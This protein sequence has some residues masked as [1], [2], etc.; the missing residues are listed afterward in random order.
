MTMPSI[1]VIGAGLSGTITALNLVRATSADTRVIVFERGA[2]FGPGLAYATPHPGHLL[3]VPAGRMSAFADR[4]TDFLDWLR[5][6][7][8]EERGG[9]DP[10]PGT[11]A[12]RASYGAYAGERLRQ[13]CAGEGAGRLV[14][15]RDEVVGLREAADGITITLA[16]GATATVTAAV[17]AS[18][19]FTPT[20]QPG[21]LQA[22]RPDGIAALP[23][24]DPVLLIGSGLTMVDTVIT[25]LD[26]GHAGPIHAISRRGLLPRAHA[27]GLPAATPEPLP[28]RLTTATLFRHLR[29]QIQ[30][31]EAAGQDWRPIIDLL[32]PRTQAIWMGLTHADR[33]RFLRH[34]RPWWDVHRH[35][36]APAIAARIGAALATGQLRVHAARLV[37]RSAGSATIRHRGSAAPATLPARH[38]IDCTGVAPDITRIQ[39]RLLT[40]LLVGGTVRP[41]A[42]RLGLE[43]T[44]DN[45]VIR[46]DG[47]PSGR[48]FAV[49]PLTKGVFWEITAVPDIRQQGA[50]LARHL[51]AVLDAY[52][53]ARMQATPSRSGGT[54][55]AQA[56]IA[57]AQRVR[58]TQPDGGEDGL[59]GSPGSNIRPR[60]LD[61][62]SL[63]TADKSAFV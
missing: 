33:Q 59:G 50:A 14:A 48:L 53:S 62:S 38:V 20:P 42:L 36:M 26:Q 6:R 16:S 11:F 8:A 60:R 46:H 35:R 49:G 40:D 10:Q 1:A 22:W 13:G 32:R 3:N 56:G 2:A 31:A 39:D 30:A 57:S 37:D 47:S 34:A 52:A 17:L 61:G 29:R 25:L 5:A 12:P 23:A 4:D 58:N 15:V 21:T 24:A 45:A 51:A 19:N 44:T 41:D 55:D 43:V 63:G 27:A 54:D 18:G 28:G 7:P 9:V